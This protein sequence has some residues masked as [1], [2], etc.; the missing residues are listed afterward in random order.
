MKLD[1]MSNAATTN[2]A[3]LV[4][5]VLDGN[6]E[7][8]GLLVARYQSS[9]C[10]LAY[11]ACGNIS[12]S[13][14]LAQEAFIIAWRK[15]GELEAPAKFKAWLRGIAKNLVN[16][17]CRQQARNPLAASDPLDENLSATAAASSPTEH[18]IGKEEE[19]ILWRSLEQIPETYREPLVLYYREHQSIERL[20]AV[21]ELSEEAARQRLSRG[22]KL[23][24]ER[25]IA[26][27]EGALE[28][29]APGPAFTLCVL[30]ALPAMTFSA[31]A[32]TLGAATKAGAAA[33]GAGLAGLFG[34]FLG[35]FFPFVG[36]W[37]DYRQLKKAGLPEP[38]LKSL[39]ATPRIRN[40]RNS[41]AN[42]VSLLKRTSSSWKRSH[43][44]RQLKA[45]FAFERI[46]QS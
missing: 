1:V 35:P 28:Q 32:A 13:E 45:D 6:R 27:V 36:M 20:A 10:A 14:D 37:A 5:Q 29:T 3:D 42:A 18:A 33:K 23:L 2:D 15:F 8:F 41:R 16:N 38:A 44:P 43:L 30:A 26:L 46:R 40:C 24:Q 34:K 22:R 17:I 39:S 4:A 31:K 9:V 25:V 11:S 21:L 7:A 19:A 12:P